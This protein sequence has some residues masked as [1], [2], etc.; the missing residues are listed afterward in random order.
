MA[1]LNNNW[2]LEPVFDFEYKS[3]EVL[4]YTQFLD[5]HFSQWEFYPYIDKLMKRIAELS[6]YSKAKISLEEKLER[7]I[8]SIDIKNQKILKRPVE[9][10]NG[11]I[12][13]LQQIIQFADLHLNKCFKQ[14]HLELETALKEIEITQLGISDSHEDHGLL[15]F[16]NQ[17]QTR[18][19][20]YN[21]RMIMRP[22]NTDVYKDVKT[23]F[24]DEVHT[25][26]LTNF[27]DLKWNI[28]RNSTRE[29][30]TNAFLVESNTPVPHFEMLLPM[31]KNYL[32]GRVR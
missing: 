6:T 10:K 25:G 13:E 19:Y 22:G 3:Y 7:D 17:N 26:I 16:K 15:L 1:I 8:D 24:L 11:I 12:A 18:I 2:F 20:S 30:G 32:I 9:D 27:N 31:A 28:I 5:N 4:G 14:A 29:L 23:I 21:L